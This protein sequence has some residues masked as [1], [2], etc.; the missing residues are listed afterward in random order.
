LALLVEEEGNIAVEE[1]HIAVEGADRDAVIDH[2][3][4]T[5]EGH[6]VAAEEQKSDR[7]KVEWSARTWPSG[8]R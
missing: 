7:Q 3:L 2:S 6:L 4:Q 5:R 8:R 1:E